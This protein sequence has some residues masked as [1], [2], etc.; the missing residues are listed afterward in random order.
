MNWRATTSACFVEPVA[1]L[2]ARPMPTRAM[3]AR[4]THP[5]PH[6]MATGAHFGRVLAGGDGGYGVPTG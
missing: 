5:T 3:T 1:F 6:E 4:T 2:T